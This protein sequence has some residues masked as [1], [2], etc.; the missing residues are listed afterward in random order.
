MSIEVW[1]SNPAHKVIG[2]RIEEERL[3]P[4]AVIRG[5]RAI[6]FSILFDKR[7]GWTPE[8][9]EAWLKSHWGKPYKDVT[10]KY[11]KRA[12]YL[13]YELL[14]SEEVKKYKKYGVRSQVWSKKY[15]IVVRYVFTEN[16][17]PEELKE[18]R[19][20]RRV[21]RAKHLLPEIQEFIKANKDLD[22]TELSKRILDKFGV[23][24]EPRKIR[25]ILKGRK[26][27]KIKRK[28]VDMAVAVGRLPGSIMREAM[29]RLRAGE[30]KTKGQALKWAWKEAKARG[31]VSPRRRGRPK[32]LS[33]SEEIEMDV[34]AYIPIDEL[35]ESV[36]ES[37]EL[38][39][40]KTVAEILANPVTHITRTAW[41]KK[42]VEELVKRGKDAQEIADIL[43]REVIEA[44]KK[45]KKFPYKVIAT[46]VS[47]GEFEAKR[48]TGKEYKVRPTEYL[49]AVSAKP[50]TRKQ[51]TRM[52][53]IIFK[54]QYGGDIERFPIYNIIPTKK[55]AKGRAFSMEWLNDVVIKKKG[56]VGNAPH[57][58]AF[59][60]ACRKAKLDP[61]RKLTEDELRS[62]KKTYW[63][64]LQEIGKAKIDKAKEKVD[65]L[66][67]ATKLE[68]IFEILPAEK[69]E[70]KYKVWE[71]TIE[72]LEEELPK[73]RGRRKVA[74]TVAEDLG[75]DLVAS[76]V[77][78]AVEEEIDEEV[79]AFPGYRDIPVF[80]GDVFIT[81]WIRQ[82]L[83]IV[84]N[85]LKDRLPGNIK[86][87]AEAVS[88]WLR[89]VLLFVLADLWENQIYRRLPVTLPFGLG[90][91]VGLVG[92]TIAILDLFKQV[93]GLWSPLEKVIPVESE[94]GVLPSPSTPFRE[95]FIETHE[96]IPYG[97][98][99][100]EVPDEL[101]TG[102]PIEL[103]DEEVQALLGIETYKG[104]TEAY[105]G[106]EEYKGE[107]GAYLGS[108]EYKGG[109]FELGSDIFEE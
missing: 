73:R 41:F 13:H 36:A 38:A 33:I 45:H 74:E 37:I 104:E 51:V 44:V 11:G 78:E 26:K 32:G 50:I 12:K 83:K 93:K 20:R 48:K 107:T 10:Y 63:L 82:L 84:I 31:L 58:V 90:R 27:R 39:P 99:K 30:F 59:V 25:K 24:I 72:K 77:E 7:K 52:A 95:D 70:P 4:E 64:T 92:K 43:S 54:D 9:A 91:F 85:W 53:K 66:R 14:P 49:R 94:V 69:Y 98:V 87:N 55:P 61:T 5:R 16:F 28:E 109:E 103:T 97:T 2:Q 60:E 76:F 89:P 57:L 68:E 71:K 3:E 100:V 101:L 1:A 23:A 65:K 21:P 22:E 34:S 56:K 17:R 81:I 86:G 96:A 106:S 108:E 8:K 29:E 42:R 35:P 105:L 46:K 15:G 6:V 75:S 19:L 88:G 80:A 102:E 79:G 67:K 62:L 18:K 40:Y 47:R